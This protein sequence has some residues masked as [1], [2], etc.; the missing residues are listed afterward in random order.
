[1]FVRRTPSELTDLVG[2]TVERL[3]HGKPEHRVLERVDESLQQRTVAGGHRTRS[4]RSEVLGLELEPSQPLG[5]R[6]TTHSR[7]GL[8]RELGVVPRVPLRQGIP[9]GRVEVL[10]SVLADRLEQPVAVLRRVAVV[11]DHQRSSHQGRQEVEHVVRGDGVVAAH[12]LGCVERAAASEDREPRKE[13]LLDGVEEVE[14]PVDRGTQR[15][16]TLNRTTG[17]TGQ[18]AET[19]IQTL[20]DLRRAEHPDSGRGQFDRQRDPVEADHDLHHRGRVLLGELEVTAHRGGALHEQPARLAAHDHDRIGA[21]RDRERRHPDHVLTRDAQRLTAR[22]QDRYRRTSARELDDQRRRRREEML[23]V[24]DDEEQLLTPERVEQRPSRR[25][26]PAAPSARTPRRRP[27]RP[28]PVHEP[29]RARSPTHRGGTGA[30]PPPPPGAPSASS[31]HRRCRSGSRSG[32]RRGA[33]AAPAP[34]ARG[35]RT[36]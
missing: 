13:P 7:E 21:R 33:R 25:P 2:E 30:A 11:G 9:V 32:A 16:V 14:R 24:V 31:P 12:R 34:H 4:R 18:K 20:G 26:R 35:P 23:A 22:R 5:R 29:G 6:G 8:L 1:M 36:R 17:A 27:R 19:L 3:G 15:R 10:L 28:R